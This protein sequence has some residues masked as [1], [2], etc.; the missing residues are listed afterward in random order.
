[1]WWLRR[2]CGDQTLKGGG[3]GLGPLGFWR[4][5]RA[6]GARRQHVHR[7]FGH[8]DGYRCGT[9]SCIATAVI[10]FVEPHAWKKCGGVVSG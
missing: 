6:S 10:V 4:R 7:H 5:A 1:V 3:L 9:P 2:V 8:T